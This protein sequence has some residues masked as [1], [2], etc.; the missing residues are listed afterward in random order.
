MRPLGSDR[1]CRTLR[2][3]TSRVFWRES[4]ASPKSPRGARSRTSGLSS[5]NRD[6]MFSRSIRGRRAADAEKPR[7]ERDV[8][9]GI[10]KRESRPA[11]VSASAG[12]SARPRHSGHRDIRGAQERAVPRRHQGRRVG[13]VP[14]AEEI[15][16]IERATVNRHQPSLRRSRTSTVCLRPRPQ[17]G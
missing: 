12:G 16:D 1:T 8:A 15:Q 14:R 17:D 13:F 6:F 9:V 3:P 5:T 10:L 2:A 11:S 7:R 4:L